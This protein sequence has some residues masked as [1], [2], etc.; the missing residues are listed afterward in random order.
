MSDPPSPPSDIR[1]QFG[2]P[3]TDHSHLVLLQIMAHIETF[4]GREGIF[5]KSGSKQRVD[6]LV[7]DLR[8]KDF[9]EILLSGVYKPHDYTSMLKQF[10]SELPEPLFLKRHLEAYMQTS[11]GHLQFLSPHAKCF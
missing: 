11:G 4:S 1:L 8:E 9:E 5:R 2:S 7:R 3:M 10:F 6:K